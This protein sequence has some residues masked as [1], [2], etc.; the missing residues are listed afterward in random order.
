MSGFLRRINRLIKK[1]KPLGR[2]LLTLFYADGTKRTM[3][4][5]VDAFLEVL[6]GRVKSVHYNNEEDDED[7]FY[8]ALMS[9]EHDINK[10]FEDGDDSDMLEG[11][12]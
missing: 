2:K 10:L 9:G 8:T 6:S 11:V 3:V 12:E 4:D 1:I 5:D 7:G